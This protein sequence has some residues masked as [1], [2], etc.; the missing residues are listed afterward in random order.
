[1]TSPKRVVAALV[2]LCFFCTGAGLAT[3]SNTIAYS[4]YD[5]SSFSVEYP[6]NWEV[7]R[8]LS[9]EDEGW[10][11]MFTGN[12]LSSV[13][14]QD[15]DI[16]D[17]SMKSIEL[18]IGADQIELMVLESLD[19]FE[20]GRFDESTQHFL[21]TLNFKGSSTGATAAPRTITYV[22]Y[23]NV[24]FNVE[25]PQDW[26]INKGQL[27]SLSAITYMFSDRSVT[28]IAGVSFGTAEHLG[29]TLD[30]ASMFVR[31]PRNSVSSGKFG[32]PIQHFLDTLT[33]KM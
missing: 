14:M 3:E 10:K 26:I 32:M 5:T 6:S 8:S 30:F 33:F 1:M 12:D 17:A 18:T 16:A 4:T 15:P 21:D 9:A 25:Y 2:V 24:Y 28:T 23:D 11:Y 29:Q 27:E 7:E 22:P 13:D 20:T 31:T 19:N